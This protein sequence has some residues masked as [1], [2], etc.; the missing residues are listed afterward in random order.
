MGK[1]RAVLRLVGIVLLTTLVTFVLV[2][3]LLVGLV[4]VRGRVA[5]LDWCTASWARACIWVMGVRVQVAGTPPQPPFFLVSNHLSY[6]DIFVLYTRLRG[7]FLAKAEVSSWPLFGMVSRLAGTM[8]I[9]R[10]RRRDLS[11]VLPEVQS[12]LDGGRGVLVFPEG[13]STRGDVV[14]PF[15]PSIFEVPIRAGVPVSYAA[16]SY[17]TPEGAPPAH[18]AVCWWGDMPFLR[19]FFSLLTLP[20]IDAT[21]AFGSHPVSADDRKDLALRA[22]RAVESQFTPV[23][24]CEA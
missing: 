14:H 13:T 2:L 12:T 10:G 15:K 17:R 16:L 1:L 23:V 24:G 8:Y 18:L 6:L 9:D 4:S 20:R 5:L 7:R 21:V 3:A 19:H 22:Q 11:R